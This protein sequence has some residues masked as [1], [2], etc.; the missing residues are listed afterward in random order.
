MQA[1]TLI[2]QQQLGHST[3]HRWTSNCT[4]GIRSGAAHLTRTRSAAIGIR[5]NL[6]RN[7]GIEVHCTT[8]R[9]ERRDVFSTLLLKRPCARWHG[10]KHGSFAFCIQECLCVEQEA[11]RSRISA[12]RARGAL[13]AARHLGILSVSW[14]QPAAAS[15][16]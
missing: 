16:M 9:S 8:A 10:S 2:Y 11:G 5:A 4:N 7:V 14:N 3:T 6:E 15:Y 1:A 13:G 12:A